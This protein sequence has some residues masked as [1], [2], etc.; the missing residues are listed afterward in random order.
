MKTHYETVYAALGRLFHAVAACDG[1]VAA[2]EQR[3]LNELIKK[4]WLPFEGSTD[5]YG[6]DAAHY[7]GFAFDTAVAQRAPV[8]ED[9]SAFKEALREH[10]SLITEEM[11]ALI[12]ETA[13]EV[14]K[15]Y[16]GESDAEQDL[17]ARLGQMLHGKGMPA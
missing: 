11:R 8:E 5:A 6:T 17:L 9:F 10:P 12:W 14:A 4:R 13:H 3:S 2:D 16:G 15:A 7:I 1:H